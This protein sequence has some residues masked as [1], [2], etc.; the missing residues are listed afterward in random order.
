[1]SENE[2]NRFSHRQSLSIL[3]ILYFLPAAASRVSREAHI[4]EI[5]QFLIDPTRAQ[6]L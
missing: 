5:D 6:D 4:H 2:L 3:N 1:M